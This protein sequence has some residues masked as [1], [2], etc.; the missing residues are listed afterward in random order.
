MKKEEN[1]DARSYPAADQEALRLKAIEA[2]QSGV[3]Q[4]EVA[5]LYGVTRQAVAKWVKAYREGGSKALKT[6]RKGRPQGG[7]LQSWQ[8]AHIVRTLVKHLPDQLELG[9]G[10]WTRENVALL[11]RQQFGVRLSRWTVGR[12]L[13]RWGLGVQKFRHYVLGRRSTHFE[14]EY[15]QI[16]RWARRER[17][18]IYWGAAVE[19]HIGHR[20][21][22]QRPETAEGS[23]ALADVRPFSGHVISAI[24]NRGLL[25]FMVIDRLLTAETL[26]DFLARLVQHSPYKV[27]LMVE[28][29]P[30]YK[31]EIVRVWLAQHAGGIR[32][33][34]LPDDGEDQSIDE[35]KAAG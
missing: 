33:F 12:Y 29:H 26:L 27:F 18:R 30:L 22:D 11:V 9:D 4:G 25:K 31:A 16:R 35:M 5:R 6:K 23:V 20:A 14:K 24:N 8:V 2:V 13:T 28:R 21:A 7:R 19:V 32:L 34:F 15:G 17:A 3:K 1:K 10:L